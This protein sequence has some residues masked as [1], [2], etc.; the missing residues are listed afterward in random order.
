MDKIKAIKKACRIGDIIF[1]ELINKFKGFDTEKDVEKFILDEIKKRGLKPSFEPI[2][3]AGNNAADPHH[4]PNKTKL[5]KGFVV[6]DFGVKYKGYCSDM[7]RMIY[8]GKPSKKELKMYRLLIEVQKKSINKLKIGTKYSDIDGFARKKLGKYDKYFVHSL[9]HG[10][11]KKIHQLPKI[12]KT[13]KEKVKDKDIVTIEPG[14]YIDNELGI[15]IEDTI[16]V[17]K[18]ENIILT[19]TRKKLWVINKR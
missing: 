2:I 1:K 14:I 16:A 3:A 12:S 15:R 9:G 4:K 6:M 19:K 5:K 7:T 17:R 18:K 11:G 10:V 13:S 8:I